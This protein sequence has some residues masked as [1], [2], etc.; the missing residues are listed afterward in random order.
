MSR[1]MKVIINQDKIAD[2]TPELMAEVFWNMH[3]EQQ[4]EFFHQ[5]AVVIEKYN[6]DHDNKAYSYGE[7]QWLNMTE[8][9]RERSSK[10]SNMFLSFSAFAYDFC[11]QKRQL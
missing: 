2:L 4:A 7:M 11:P 1:T 10:A 9:I 5:L 6:E 8:K 3:D